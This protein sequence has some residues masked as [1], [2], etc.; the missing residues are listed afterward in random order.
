MAREIGRFGREIGEKVRD[1]NVEDRDAIVG[2]E[3][4]EKKSEKRSWDAKE[5]MKKRSFEVL[6]LMKQDKERAGNYKLRSFE[7]LKHY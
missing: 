1:V 3:E 6:K 2:Q 5:K 4:E 7:E